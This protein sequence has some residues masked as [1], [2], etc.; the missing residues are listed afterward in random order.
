MLQAEAL[1]PG[2]VYTAGRE[3]FCHCLSAV[4]KHAK[5]PAQTE[6]ALSDVGYRFGY[7]LYRFRW[8]KNYFHDILW[9]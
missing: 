2:C 7:R 8:K 5:S 3:S 6:T 1:S 4:L 9:P